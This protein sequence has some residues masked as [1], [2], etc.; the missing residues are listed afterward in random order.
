MTRTELQAGIVVLLAATLVCAGPGPRWAAAQDA[1]AQHLAILAGQLID[2]RSDLPLSDAAVLI[3]GDRIVAVGGQEVVP[4]DV[5]VID[6][7][8][9]TLMPGLI[10]SHTHPLI[11][12]DSYQIDHLRWSSAYKALR[13]LRAVQDNLMAGWTTIRIA[14]DADIFYA[15]LDVRRAID[16]G[17]FVGP[18]IT[19]AGHYISV[20]GGGGDINFMAPEQTRIAD[21]LVV[22]GVDEIRKAVREEIKNGSDWIKLLVSGAYMSV[23]DDPRNV[24]FSPGEL[25]AAVEEA[26][27]R[28]VPVMAHS[29][30]A[31]GIKMAVRAG[32]RSIEHGSFIDDE[33]IALMVEHGTWLVPT[34]VIGSYYLDQDEVVDE[35]D[36]MVDLTRRYRADRVARLRKAI[37][38]GVKVAVGSDLGGYP[39][40]LNAGEFECMVE[41]GMTPMQ[42]IQSGTRVGAELLGWE[43]RIGTVEPGK[44]A[45]LVAV[46]GNPL[47][48]ISEM[49][50][51]SFVMIGGKVVKGPTEDASVHR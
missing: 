18:R 28:G 25:A 9:A 22:D 17:L 31:E 48:D 47:E 43:D 23:G 10:D 27:R 5:P 29:H 6:L 4:E 44:L 39:A 13:G 50:R 34:G 51:V 37:A 8:G 1:A 26:N 16:E 40:E 20:T 14:G 41:A 30:S 21:G 24:H 42:A 33:G 36:K 32:V 7:G 45:D 2:G 35:L 12:T 11:S 15:H 3:E 46:P 49:K 38:A 19:G